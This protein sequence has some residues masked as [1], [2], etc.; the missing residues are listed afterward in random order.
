MASTVEAILGA[1]ELDGGS[2][3]LMRVATRLGLV[4]PLLISVTSSLPFHPLSETICKHN[5]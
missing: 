3:A 1:V 5:W 4:H 2:E